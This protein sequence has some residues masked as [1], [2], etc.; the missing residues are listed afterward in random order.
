MLLF[1]IAVDHIN[2]NED[3]IIWNIFKSSTVVDFF[4]NTYRTWHMSIGG[5][6]IDAHTCGLIS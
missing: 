4:N 5:F 1:L 2:K 6:M 3:S